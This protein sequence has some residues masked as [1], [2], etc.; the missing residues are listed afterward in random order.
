[1][2]GNNVESLVA[3]VADPEQ[4]LGSLL[5]S[6]AHSNHLLGRGDF[7]GAQNRI[8][9]GYTERTWSRYRYYYCILISRL[10]E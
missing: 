6:E 3:G 4:A 5:V 9:I 10:E 7:F 8:A 2:K 1:V